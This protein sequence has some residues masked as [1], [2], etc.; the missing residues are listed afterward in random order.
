MNNFVGV[1]VLQALY[2]LK[3]IHHNFQF[4]QA[5]SAAQQL[6]EWLWFAEF[7][8]DIDIILIFE[9]MFKTDNMFV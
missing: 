2:Y 1:H 8:K 9:E 3:C 4:V 6:V 5:F 7:E